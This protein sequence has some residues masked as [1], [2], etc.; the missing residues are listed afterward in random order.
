VFNEKL[1][2]A[3]KTIQEQISWTFGIEEE[4][5]QGVDDTAGLL[6]TSASPPS[7]KRFSLLPGREIGLKM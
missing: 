2:E 1:R 4:S 3:T 5:P 6:E 7:S